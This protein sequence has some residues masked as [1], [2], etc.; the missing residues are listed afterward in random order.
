MWS[1][2]V[3]WL[4]KSKAAKVGAGVASGSGIL[5]LV[6]GLHYDVT[7]RIDKVKADRAEYVQLVLEPVNRE[8]SHVKD[9]IDETKDMVRDIHNHLLKTK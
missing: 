9:G 6:L 1:L 4:V 8:I 7:N 3:S 5:G 2:L